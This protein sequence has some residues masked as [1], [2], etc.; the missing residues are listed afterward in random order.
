M[1]GEPVAKQ[2]Q[3]T[4]RCYSPQSEPG[5]Q[6]GIK[7]GSGEGSDFWGQ[8]NAKRSQNQMIISSQAGTRTNW[9][10][11]S[12]KCTLH[13]CKDDLAKSAKSADLELKRA[14]A[15]WRGGATGVLNA[16]WYQVCQWA[17]EQKL[18]QHGGCH[19]RTKTWLKVGNLLGTPTQH[20]KTVKNCVQCK[21]PILRMFLFI[22][23]FHDYEKESR[24]SFLFWCS[25]NIECV[26]WWYLIDMWTVDTGWGW[27]VFR[28][29]VLYTQVCVQVCILMPTCAQ[30][31]IIIRV[32]IS[33]IYTAI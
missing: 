6:A 22:F 28:S 10:R 21:T 2:Q 19:M 31:Y 1:G 20:A 13:M 26:I 9:V 27:L 4:N 18:G 11:S 23:Y 32:T 25:L 16:D 29:T 15:D 3:N 30:V 5:Y 7:F 33:I 8:I 17:E 14:E 24:D 12:Q